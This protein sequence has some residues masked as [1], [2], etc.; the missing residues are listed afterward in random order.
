MWEA[1]GESVGGST[2]RVN[3]SLVDG[4]CVSKPASEGTD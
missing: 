2:N 1:S 3:F 4:T